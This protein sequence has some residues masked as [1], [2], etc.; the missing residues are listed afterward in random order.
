MFRNIISDIFSKTK[1][2][3]FLQFELR[4]I[5]YKSG[6]VVEKKHKF[7]K[8]LSKQWIFSNYFDKNVFVRQ[9]LPVKIYT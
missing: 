9:I 3:M 8:K 7:C 2:Q 1:W 5:Q 6:E 4:K